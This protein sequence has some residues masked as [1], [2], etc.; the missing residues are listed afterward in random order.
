[1]LMTYSLM[2]PLSSTYRYVK[3]KLGPNCCF[4]S[5]AIRTGKRDPPEKNNAIVIYFLF[6]KNI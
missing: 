3:L 6:P 5:G 1:M 2:V 4:F